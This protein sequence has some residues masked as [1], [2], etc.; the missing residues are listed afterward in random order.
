ML[1]V[2]YHIVSSAI[3]GWIYIIKNMILM[4]D[5]CNSCYISPSCGS[6]NQCAVLITS[7]STSVDQGPIIQAFYQIALQILWKLFLLKCLFQRIEHVPFLSMWRELS[8]HMQNCGLVELFFVESQQCVFSSDLDFIKLV[9][10]GAWYLR[11][12][13]ITWQ[14]GT[15]KYQYIMLYHTQG[16]RNCR[17]CFIHDVKCYVFNHKLLL[18]NDFGALNPCTKNKNGWSFT[19]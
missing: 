13:D 17:Q 8:W 16:H 3:H 4:Y 14:R 10:N 5:Y 12:Y 6:A 19:T 15:G 1:S 11:P 18:V 2:K 7:I 9:W